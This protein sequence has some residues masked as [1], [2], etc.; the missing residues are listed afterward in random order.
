MD[1]T[2][3]KY[4]CIVLAGGEGKRVNGRDKGLIDYKNKPLIQ[5]VLETV[6][7]QVDEIILSANRNV[8][9]YK[10][11]GYKVVSDATEQ[12]RG[13][14]AGIAAALPFCNHEWVFIIPC[15]MPFIPP[16]SVIKLSEQINNNRLCV[17][18][19]NDKLQLMLLVNKSV[20]PSIHQSLENEQFKLMQWVE[21]QNPSFALFSNG[22][23]FSNF[24]NSCDF[25]TQ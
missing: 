21:S 20:L 8:D 24:N 23:N 1:T 12:Y 14:L 25:K 9:A 6:V 15:D 10:S 2:T 3:I 11:Y 19:T 5:H 17:A 4:S 7:P 22:Q 13:P 18:K 16:T